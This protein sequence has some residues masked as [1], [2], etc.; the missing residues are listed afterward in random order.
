MFNLT[1]SQKEKA[2]QNA[3]KA[4]E[5]FIYQLSLRLAIDPDSIDFDSNI[6][7]PEESSE[8]Y[9]SYV[10]LYNAI[11]DLKKIKG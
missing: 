10:V 9:S 5:I 7:L 2:K 4:K 1:D 3:L 6:N 8:N 11:E